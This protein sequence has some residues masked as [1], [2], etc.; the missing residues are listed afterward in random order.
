MT[1]KRG[2][3]QPLIVT[4][5][6]LVK[7]VD[8][9]GQRLIYF[10]TSREGVIDRQGED[11]AS[12]ALWR[13]RD[14]FVKDGNFDINHFSWLG[15]PYGSGMRPEYVVGHPLEVKRDGPSIHVKGFIFKNK[16]PPPEGSPGAWADYLWHSLTQQ[17]PPMRWY[18]SVFGSVL[19]SETVKRGDQTIRYITSVDWYSVGFAQ[20]PQHPSLPPIQTAPTE[21]FADDAKAARAGALVMD[22]PTLA[23]AMTVGAPVTDSALKTGVQALT[24]E[25]RDA[26]PPAYDSIAPRIMER[27]LRRAT[28]AKRDAIHKAFRAAGCDATTAREYTIRLLTEAG[29]ALA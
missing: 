28:P 21:V 3:Y 17:H 2:E 26:A 25:S 24:P 13:S 20:R 22:F 11:I 8:D 29:K 15:N 1:L 4:L 12:K 7:A 23:K 5:A 6:P 19:A 18:P 9:G 16:T 14:R 10:E 27:L